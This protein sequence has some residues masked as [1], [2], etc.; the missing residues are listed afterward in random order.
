MMRFEQVDE[1]SPLRYEV[2]QLAFS[3]DGQLLMGATDAGPI[4]LWDRAPHRE[5]WLQPVGREEGIGSI[6]FHGQELHTVSFIP[7]WGWTRP[8]TDGKAYIRRSDREKIVQLSGHAV[9][10]TGATYSPIAE[11]AV[12]IDY[13]RVIRL[14]DTTTGQVV[15]AYDGKDGPQAPRSRY[16][17]P[18]DLVQFSPDGQLVLICG[19]ECH[20][21]L[22]AYLVDGDALLPFADAAEV[23]YIRSMHIVPDSS[24][25][26]L[27]CADSVLIYTLPDLIKEREIRI[28]QPGKL[29]GDILACA[30]SPNNDLLALVDVNAQVWLWQRSLENF[31]ATFQPHPNFAAFHRSPG[32]P[33]YSLNNVAWSPDGKLLA[34]GGYYPQKK[35]LAFSIRLWKWAR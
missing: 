13:E 33:F 28:P 29:G 2:N 4:H 25:V 21:R 18:H 26:L 32:A 8:Y 7:A 1:F 6:V 35:G 10:P 12:T 17:I 5:I 14:W 11:R 19:D 20:S 30:M 23:L 9:A 34:T 24:L 16:T 3:P 27:E 31:V 15:T 22:H